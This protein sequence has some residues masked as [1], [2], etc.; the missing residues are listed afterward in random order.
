MTDVYADAERLTLARFPN[1]GW[2]HIG[3]VLDDSTN[4][5]FKADI[6]L[7]P[8]ADEPS[9]M[10]TGF[11]R[12]Y[13]AD[14]TEAPEKL[15]PAT[16]LVTLGKRFNMVIQSK[17]PWFIVNAIHALDRPGEWWLDRPNGKLYL[18][19]PK[20]ARRFALSFF[21]KPFFSLN[22]VRHF[23]V[24]GAADCAVGQVMLYYPHEKNSPG[25]V[26]A[27]TRG[28]CVVWSGMRAVCLER[29]VR[30]CRRP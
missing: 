8:W 22:G 28:A 7:T 27:K 11:W 2:L 21:D 12:H 13:W 18:W 30:P 1:E 9:L 25:V 29:C 24:P 6:D 23:A 4:R 15:D 5:V 26:A 19:P 20:G 14:L 17:R 16:G 3:E 10:L